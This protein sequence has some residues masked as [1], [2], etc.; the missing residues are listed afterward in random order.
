MKLVIQR[1]TRASVTVDQQVVGK[2]GKG[3]LV[4]I[5]VANTDTKEIADKIR[6][7]N[8]DKSVSACFVVGG[9]GKIHGFTELLS[10]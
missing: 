2:I 9:G 3:F 10:Q 8:G 6:E 1:V 7:L 5:G 4:L